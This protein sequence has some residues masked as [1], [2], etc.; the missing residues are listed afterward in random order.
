MSDWKPCPATV[1]KIEAARRVIE[2]AAK[3]GFRL[4]LRAVFYRMLARNIIPNTKQAYK[5]L[6]ATL[7][8]ARW[9]GMLPFDCIDDP[10][11]SE[12]VGKTWGSV[13]EC[14]ED[15]ARTYRTDWWSHA[16]PVVEVWAEKV[17][18]AGI[19]EEMVIDRCGV[20]FVAGLRYSSLTHLYGAACRFAERPGG[21]VILYVGDHDPSGLD[22]DRDLVARLEDLGREL[23]SALS[24]SL[25]RVA[26]TMD[27]IEEYNLP[28]QP[29]KATD[30]RAAGYGNDGSWEL[31]ALP[32]AVLADVVEGAIRDRLPPDFDGRRREDE[33]A[34][35]RLWSMA[36]NA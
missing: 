13:R 32:A 23:K 4:T 16:D 5:S 21:T 18:V 22:M 7:V 31:D 26:L 25:K 29:T 10:E 1:A 12:L 8:K 30:S 15:A 27:Q 28:S 34:Q 6:S 14:L 36:A 19:L 2:E 20:L 35:D 17:A 24:V 33:S 9:A 3:G 11:R